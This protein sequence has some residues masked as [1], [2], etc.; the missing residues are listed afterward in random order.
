MQETSSRAEFADALRKGK[1]R[2]MAHIRAH[3][4][5]GVEDLLLDACLH[6]LSY[7]SQSEGWRGDWMM[8]MLSLLPDPGPYHRAVVEAFRE[9][10]EFNDVG[11][12]GQM[13]RVMAADGDA[14][15][16]T[17]LYEKFAQ[18]RF[19]DPWVLAMGIIALDGVDGALHVGRVLGGRLLADP[20]YQVDGG[21]GAQVREAGAEQ[22]VLDA[23]AND[24]ALQRFADEVLSGE[25]VVR[26][27]ARPI[28]SLPQFLAEIDEGKKH[29]VGSAYRFGRSAG[30][31]EL[32][33]LLALCAVES[34][35]ARLAAMLM[36]FR[37]TKVPGGSASLLRY[38]RF[39]DGAVR[40]AAIS[41]L[42][43]F[44]DDA[45]AALA[46]EMLAVGSL[47]GVGLLEKNTVPG[48]FAR[49]LALLPA[50]PDE[51]T[52]HELGLA[53]LRI[54]RAG[55]TADMAGW[56]LWVYEQTP[57]SFCRNGSVSDLLELGLLPPE[58]C[59]ECRDDC[60][61]ET[62]ELVASSD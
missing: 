41:G 49:V 15:A 7:D 10:T 24:A 59:S 42:E 34:D 56:L 52:A 48:Q 31:T 25:V 53:I 39:P 14:A 50:E 9:S 35:P 30:E 1:G 16:R 12:M 3:G 11:Q 46:E 43:R 19:Q 38:A 6:S 58:L 2:A 13:L 21:V 26:K 28:V 17:A 51:R 32:R 8:E 33:Q 44:K 18:P 57:C 22:A 23:A 55:R 61:F 62:R 27:R 29:T 20:E 5:A 40:A 37:R 36:V 47:E 54:D 4:D 60:N 45:V